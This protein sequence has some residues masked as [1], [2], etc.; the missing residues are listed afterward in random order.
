MWMDTLATDPDTPLR[1][2]TPL[3]QATVALGSV[4]MGAGMTVSFVVVAPL[5]RDAGLTEI[6]VAG[7][8]TLSTLIYTVMIP[9]WGRL[10]D[11]Y[12]R[13][14]I[15]VFS[16]A[17]MGVMNMLFL[18]ALEAA[19]AGMVTGASTLV[20]LAVTRL[21]YG[22]LSPGLQPASMAAMT[23]ASTL[24]TRAAT[25]GLL[26]AAMSFGS[27]LGPAGAAVL[28][29][30]G[31]LAPL[32]GSIILCW[33][34]AMIIGLALP[35]AGKSH[36]HTTRKSLSV[37]D[38]RVFPHL[39]F[40]FSYFVAV[41]IIQQ[42]IAWLVKDRYD[43]TRTEAVEYAGMVLGALALAMVVTQF[44]F[45]QPVKP[46]PRKALSAGLVFIWVGYVAAAF[47]GTFWGM[48]LA[49]ALVG[50]GS[51]LAVP[52]ANALGSL[53]VTRHEQ[54]SAAALLSAAPPAG[55]I[56]GPLMGASLYMASPI[57]P[58]L[59]GAMIM[60]TLSVYAI[61]VTA[62]RPIRTED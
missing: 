5:A 10:A 50:V 26:G 38:A 28:A 40:L 18:F 4:A 19:L 25:L 32:W 29:Q 20:L 9:A 44:A 22:F 13:K 61:M 55:F 2:L 53:S 8:L 21:F 31:A 47:S 30:Y 3:Q 58:L 59:I 46:D 56:I 51:A 6:E 62:R 35:R 39:A 36:V 49:F 52:S 42:T 57:L 14:S 45:M 54:A 37:R 41:G 16:L 48:A 33:I 1:P 12:G 60:G 43:L 34:A 17:A 15:M 11:R 23:D 7:V 27:I 24:H